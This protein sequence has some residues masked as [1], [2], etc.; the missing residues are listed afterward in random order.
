[1][2]DIAGLRLLEGGGCAWCAH[3]CR[4]EGRILTCLRKEDPIVQSLHRWAPKR[5]EEGRQEEKKVV[6]S[7]EPH[8]HC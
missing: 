5:K 2:V 4:G 7:A 1:M 3:V 6:I 8:S